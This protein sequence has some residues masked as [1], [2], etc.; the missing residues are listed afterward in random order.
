M[1]LDK[2]Q[3][4]PADIYAWEDGKPWKHMAW[5]TDSGVAIILCTDCGEIDETAKFFPIN[6]VYSNMGTPG[7]N[8]TDGSHLGCNVCKSLGFLYVGM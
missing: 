3:S 4:I 6:T 1:T 2:T 8:A 7:D 5:P